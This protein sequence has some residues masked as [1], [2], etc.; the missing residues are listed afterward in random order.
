M[1]LTAPKGE[2]GTQ[3]H[4]EKLLEWGLGGQE[5]VG[6]HLGKSLHG[7]FRGKEQAK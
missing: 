6:W 2:R 5:V 1:L 4:M 7:G 3:G